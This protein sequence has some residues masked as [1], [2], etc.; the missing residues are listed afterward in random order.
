M[1]EVEPQEREERSG[2]IKDN[3]KSK[4]QSKYFIINQYSE[5]IKKLK[6]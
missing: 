4:T 1:R 5:D 3:N 6:P 2:S